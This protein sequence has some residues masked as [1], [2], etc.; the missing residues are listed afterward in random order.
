MLYSDESIIDQNIKFD[1]LDD[2]FSYTFLQYV[3]HGSVGVLRNKIG[4][5]GVVEEAFKTPPSS[6]QHTGY[7]CIYPNTI[8]LDK[9]YNS[10]EKDLDQRYFR[11]KDRHV[12]NIPNDKFSIY[13]SKIHIPFSEVK[14]LLRNTSFQIHEINASTTKYNPSKF[15]SSLATLALFHNNEHFVNNFK[16]EVKLNTNSSRP[17]L[18][19]LKLFM[20]CS[21]LNLF[22][23]ED[24][25]LFNYLITSN[26]S[27]KFLFNVKELSLDTR[28]QD[29]INFINS[30]TTDLQDVFYGSALTSLNEKEQF[31]GKFLLKEPNIP[32][33]IIKQYSDKFNII[34]IN[35]AVEKLDDVSQLKNN[36]KTINGLTNDQ[37]LPIDSVIKFY[38]KIYSKR[39]F[40]FI[41][42]HL[43]ISTTINNIPVSLEISTNYKLNNEHHLN[44]Y[45]ST[46]DNSA[47]SHKIIK[48]WNDNAIIFL[49]KLILEEYKSKIE[50]QKSFL[51]DFSNRNILSEKFYLFLQ[52]SR[53][54]ELK[55]KLVN[56]NTVV[57]KAKI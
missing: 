52:T 32:E 14:Y 2:Y 28:T 7:I 50:N 39:D 38:K 53:E 29:T 10:S 13:D 47:E 5:T 24:S 41:K 17:P 1:R 18:E 9:I 48:F 56:N 22:S 31:L 45:L 4:E 44:I 51:Q 55:T 40:P 54:N 23:L 33:R 42:N 49:D 8:L 30:L 36:L 15:L 11:L 27:K 43:K 46:G 6:M 20:F 37:Y 25:K 57:K 19:L 26:L 3:Y 35:H 12:E 16:R 34:D 21:K